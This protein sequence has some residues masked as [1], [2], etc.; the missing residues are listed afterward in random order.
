MSTGKY[1]GTDGFRGE[2]NQT[3]TAEHAFRIGRF[4]GHYYGQDHKARIVLGKDT[5][6]SSYMFEYALAAGITASGAD[7]YLLHVTTTPSVAYA[8]RTDGFDCGV[9]ISASH[10]P[11][12]DNG[13][14][15]INRQGE[16]MPDDVTEQIE[17]YL[18]GLTPP[19]PLAVGDSIGRAVDYAAGR[20]RYIGYLISLANHSFRGMKVGLDCANG[21]TWM[22]AKAVFDAL[23]AET[24]AI[25]CQPN[26][27][28]INLHCGSTHPESLQAL[29]AEKK[30]DA[31]FAF[32]GDGDR[33]LAVD[34][35]GRL[36]TGDM[37]LYIYGSYMKKR[38]KLTTNTVVS[39]VMSNL[40]LAKTLE[41]EGIHWMQ[42]QVGDRFVY[43]A[44]R[45]GGH[46]L[47]GEESGH[48]IF[49]KYATTG[50]GILTAMKLMQA[51]LDQK[52]PL[53]KLAE[54]F[55]LYPQELKNVRVQN[56]DAVLQ[57]PAVQA[58]Q[59]QAEAL[60]NGNGR[61]LLRKSGTEPVIR[62]MAE[63]EDPALCR[64]CVDQIAAVL[65]KEAQ[66]ERS[67]SC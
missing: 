44:M 36:I 6:Q 34:E 29:V 2:A 51:M 11:Y 27:E 37:I 46:L 50:D 7:V 5:R 15:L 65:A 53:S 19:L 10:N 13:I 58:A 20:N 47:G 61:V 16:K 3:L 28:N 1:F 4:L 38:E 23:G 12:T 22:I 26:G 48:I 67:R 24:C 57:S 49:A 8:A 54:P 45:Q 59:A 43:E 52:Q 42:T 9:M 64:Q 63:A 25:H 30:L 17:R 31:G 40:G 60:L 55:Q 62:V 18:D 33:C 35:T 56:K 14:K 21:S 32:D 41:Q 39:T 66:N